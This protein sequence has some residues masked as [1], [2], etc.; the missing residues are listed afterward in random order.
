MRRKMCSK[1]P[2]CNPRIDVCLIQGIKDLNII[3]HYKT[4]SS[5]CGH[6]KYDP[7]VVIKNLST[8]IISEFY[9]E[10]V[11]GK[12]KCNRYYKKDIEGYYYIPE[13]ITS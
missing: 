12:R 1:L 5:C 7:T 4:L 9:T 8:G 10:M 6:G 13:L 11:L 3:P 2:Y